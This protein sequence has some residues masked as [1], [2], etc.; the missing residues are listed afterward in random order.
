MPKAST[1]AP[2]HRLALG[3]LGHVRGED[4]G[5]AALVLDHLPGSPRRVRGCR[6]T[7][8]TLRPLPGQHDG[9]RLAG[10]DA[11]SR[12]R[13][14]PR[15]TIA[16]F[17]STRPRRSGILDAI[18]PSIPSLDRR[19]YQRVSNAAPG[20]DT[21]DVGD[22]RDLGPRHLTV[23]GLARAAGGPPRRCGRTRRAAVPPESCPPQ[24]LS[25]S[26]P[27]ERD[28]VPALDE[29]RPPRRCRRSPSPRATRRP[30]W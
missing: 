30:R 12:G 5:L 22:R 8:S 26:S 18:S 2:H 19:V 7:S 14:R 1:A 21:A 20:L 28:A 29:R 24:V 25:G 3:G 27:S 10:A 17:P 11:R 15:S 9:G 16:T 4:F 23:A 6:S 13:A